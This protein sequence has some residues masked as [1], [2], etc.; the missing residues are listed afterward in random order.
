MK[1]NRSPSGAP[2]A[3]RS[4]TASANPALGE[5]AIFAR[6][7]P[8]L[9]GERRNTRFAGTEDAKETEGTEA[10]DV[11]PERQQQPVH[12]DQ[13]NEGNGEDRRDDAGDKQPVAG[14]RRARLAGMAL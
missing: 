7:P 8:Q 3:D 11:A 4:A 5:S 2:S 10:S 9:A 12:H 1:L 14:R 6:R 13:R